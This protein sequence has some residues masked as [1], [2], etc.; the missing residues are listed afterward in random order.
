MQKKE[1]G[2][3]LHDAHNR[4][5]NSEATRVVVFL[6]S[7]LAVLVAFDLIASADDADL[8]LD[9]LAFEV[10]VERETVARVDFTAHRLLDEEPCLGCHGERL[11]VTSQIA[12]RDVGACLDLV[13]R[14]RGSGR[15]VVEE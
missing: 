15:K 11:K 7:L 6:F 13:K 5:L 12:G 8:D 14:D 1:E 9:E 10:L 4:R 2:D 3:V